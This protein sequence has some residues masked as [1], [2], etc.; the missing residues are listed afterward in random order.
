ME[1]GGGTVNLV[2]KIIA[3]VSVLGVAGGLGVGIALVADALGSDTAVV[4]CG[5]DRWCVLTVRAGAA[6]CADL[7]RHG[8]DNLDDY[9]ADPQAE[10]GRTGR[11]LMAMRQTGALETWHADP[12][13]ERPEG[14]PE[15]A[16]ALP[17]GACSVRV[18]LS[19][20]Q[21]AA[22]RAVFDAA[23]Q[24]GTPGHDIVTTTEAIDPRNVE[25][26]HAW[27][28]QAAPAEYFDLARQEA[29]P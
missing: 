28:G 25:A 12:V 8:G 7:L 15:D 1:R 19:R 23:G 3:G 13:F 16:E 21:A 17:T 10:A 26:L 6:Q 4:A 2:G 29:A 18:L 24:Q 27:A 9:P 22:W 11:V 20:D 14:A 5:E